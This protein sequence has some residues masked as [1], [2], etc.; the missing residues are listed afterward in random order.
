[1]A[2]RREQYYTYE[3]WQNFDLGEGR[4][5]ELIDGD[6]YMMASPSS[7]HQ[8]IL[9]EMSRQLSNHLRGK[10]CK[11]YFGLGVQLEKNTVLIPDLIVICDPKKLTKSSYEGA[12]D[13]VV[14]VLSPSTAKYDKLTKFIL[15]QQAGV[16]EYWIV[17]PT[18]NILTI[19]RLID[20]KYTT[21]V[22]SDTDTAPVN[23][24]PGFTMDL[25]EVFIE[26]EQEGE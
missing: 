6:M 25:S 2:M 10:R 13:L 22:Y 17:D 8:A 1:M 9:M 14:E 19:H 16:P 12:P 20:G 5:A 23:A 7:R 26:D 18:D 3:D 21:S 15:Y 24:I 4:H 11:P